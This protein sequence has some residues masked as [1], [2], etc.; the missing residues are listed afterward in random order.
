MA[1]D[2]VANIYT[3][4][5]CAFGIAHDFG[6]LWKGNSSQESPLKNGKL[7][8]ELL[9]A[10]QQTKQLAIVKI[11]GHSKA[12]TMEAKGSHFTNAAARQT[13]LNSQVI[14]AQECFLLSIKSIK[15]YLL[16]F[17]KTI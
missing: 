9:D 1:K 7:V 2:Q 3:D 12:T 13:A 11:P 16:Q 17:Q 5:H 8:A 15:D 10:I 6:M 4:S 14:Q